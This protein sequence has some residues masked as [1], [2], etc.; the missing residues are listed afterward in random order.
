MLQITVPSLKSSVRGVRQTM[1][2]ETDK[3]A[4]GLYIAMSNASIKKDKAA[5]LSR[6]AKKQAGKI[7]GRAATCT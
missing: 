7:G 5:N 6:A 4:K 2:K 3:L 1:S